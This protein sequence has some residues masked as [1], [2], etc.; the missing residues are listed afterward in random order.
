MTAAVDPGLGVAN[1]DL[2]RVKKWMKPDVP[3]DFLRV[4]DTA[5]LDQ[6]FEKIFILGKALEGVRR[7]GAREALEDFEPIAFQSGVASDPEG[8]IGRERVEMGQ[9]IAGLIHDMNRH[10]AIGN[11]DVDMEPED[12]IGARDLLQVF[13]DRSVSFAL[14]DVL[15]EPMRKGMRPGRSD[16]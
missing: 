8:G 7:A 6:Q 2:E 14:G 9:K 12:E 3:P 5:R 10:R 11:A 15:I 13:H 16:F 1:P 4:I